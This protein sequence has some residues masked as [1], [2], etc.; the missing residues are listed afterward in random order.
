M[1]RRNFL[2]I[3]AS[4][5]L[6]PIAHKEYIGNIE[7][8]SVKVLPNTTLIK[9]AYFEIPEWEESNNSFSVWCD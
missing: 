1:H 6:I 5:W 7:I 4:I 3:L 9:N 2:E 8:G